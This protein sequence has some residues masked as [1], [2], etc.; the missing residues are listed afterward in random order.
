MEKIAQEDQL[1][2]GDGD[3]RFLGKLSPSRGQ[4]VLSCNAR[5]AGKFPVAGVHTLGGG[6]EGQEQAPL[7]IHGKNRD[8]GVVGMGGHGVLQS[9]GMGT[10]QRIAV[11]IE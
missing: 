9:A 4:A 8:H 11:F 1:L 3:A 5:A 10:V 6:T 7:A 2:P